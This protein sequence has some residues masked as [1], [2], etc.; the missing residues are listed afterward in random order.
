MIEKTLMFEKDV[1]YCFT[2]NP[3]D[4]GQFFKATTI[5]RMRYATEYNCKHLNRILGD[6]T[7][8]T[9]YPEISRQGRIHYH[10]YIRVNDIFNFHLFCINRLKDIYVYDIHIINDSDIWSTYIHKDKSVMKPALQALSL[11]Y[12]V[13]NKIVKKYINN[14]NKIN[15]NIIE[16]FKEIEITEN[17]FMEI[18]DGDV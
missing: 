8:F 13:N 5:Q 1:V 4:A 9:L 14:L 2:V 17:N 15:I 16:T 3:S 18:I 12:K 7:D 6:Y 11:P 10:G